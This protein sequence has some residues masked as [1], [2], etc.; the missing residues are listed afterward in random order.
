MK[1]LPVSSKLS[2]ANIAKGSDYLR[3]KLY[4]TILA[5]FVIV[6]SVLFE[7]GA[8]NLDVP[9]VPTPENVVE[10]M[11]DMVNVGPGD[12]VI[13]LGSGDGR[14]VIAAAKRGA[15]GHGVDIDPKRIREAKENAVRAGVD[16][17]VVFV[18]GNIFETDFSRANVVTMYLLSS[19]NIQLRKHLINNLKPGSRIVSHDFDMGNWEPEQTVREETS[20]I[21]FWIVPANLKG[22]WEWRAGGK[23]FSLTANQEFQE[24]QLQLK[25]GN[26]PLV[27]ENAR[28]KGD[29]ISFAAVNPSGSEKYIYS[30]RVEG[31][32][33][34]GAVQI[35]K[36]NNSTVE[37]WTADRD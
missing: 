18:Q 4:L 34:I 10:K 22:Q 28:L 19:V 11:L 29:R 31:N 5:G 24:V 33:I 20:D 7:A 9:Y 26:S 32:S 14:I 13:D 12:Y 27:V 37:N 8:Q 35:R 1:K 23:S 21:Y 2:H 15:Y 36:S 17:R 30:G 6:F 3:Q 16:G 25:S